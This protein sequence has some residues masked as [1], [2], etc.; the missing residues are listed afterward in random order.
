[1]G[2]GGTAPLFLNRGLSGGG[3]TLSSFDPF[4]PEEKAPALSDE[5]AEWAPE[6]VRMLRRRQKPLSPTGN[7]IA[8]LWLSNP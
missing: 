1:M 7:L 4:I 6:S 3:W 2:S 8:L 5:E